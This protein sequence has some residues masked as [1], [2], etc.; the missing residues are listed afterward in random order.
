MYMI[1]HTIF[2]DWERQ[3]KP[4]FFIPSDTSLMAGPSPWQA[5]WL[6]FTLA[7]L[8]VCAYTC[9]S[10]GWFISLVN[11]TAGFSLSDNW[12][13]SWLVWWPSHL[14]G[15]SHGL[16]LSCSVADSDPHSNCS[17]DNDPAS[18]CRS[19]P[20]P[21]TETQLQKPKFTMISEVFREK[22]IIF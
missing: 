5:W 8:L 4:N 1:F 14:P 15:W 13:L 10:D 19:D 12:S 17:L 16:S 11:P 22:K 6:F 20:D 7:A 21:A 2:C 9:F 18:K 3:I